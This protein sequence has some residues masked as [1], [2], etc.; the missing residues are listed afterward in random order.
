MLTLALTQPAAF[1][2]ALLSSDTFDSFLLEEAQIRTAV[3]WQLDGRLNRDF[4]DTEVWD[5]PDRRPYSYISWKEIRSTCRDLIKG[6]RAPVHMQFVLMLPPEAA[7]KLVGNVP[8]L[9]ALLLTVRG[10][11][12]EL[13]L[14]SAADFST[15]SMDKEPERTWDAA[16]M[17]FLEKK[18]IAFE[19]Q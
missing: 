3:S 2:S 19:V 13:S 5:D 15:F 16:V 14:Y 7:A 10:E 12:Q 11:G 1:M 9:R 18:G 6:R 17:K 4:Y 8:S